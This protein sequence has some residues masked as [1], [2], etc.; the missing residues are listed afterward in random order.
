MINIKTE[1]G[2]VRYLLGKKIVG[3]D[4]CKDWGMPDKVII[5]LENGGRLQFFACESE[6]EF[7]EPLEPHVD[8]HFWKA[9]EA[10]ND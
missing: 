4:F 7:G 6:C 9:K 3:I 10:S 1:K 2:F 8:L 5:H